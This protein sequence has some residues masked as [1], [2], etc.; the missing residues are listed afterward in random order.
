MPIL[1]NPRHE[2]FAQEFATGKSASE[3][4]R[5]AGYRPNR[6]HAATLKQHRNISK[7]VEEILAARQRAEAKATERAIDRTA[8]TKEWVI[9]R[10][11]ENAERAMQLSPVL[12]KK[13]NPVGEYKHDASAANRALELIG[14]E[15]GMF[16]ERRERGGPGDFQGLSNEE[17]NERL[18]ATLVDRG[19]GDAEART[20]IYRAA[21][22]PRQAPSAFG[23]SND[24]AEVGGR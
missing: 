21:P 2:R 22:P 11:R 12:D 5:S 9:E 7:R 18:V 4:Y 15:L 10:L 13:G 3:A 17:L 24:D 16:I 23:A 6:G 20:F 1:A 8:I 19:M 14:K